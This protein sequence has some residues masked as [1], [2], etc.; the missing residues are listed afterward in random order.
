[1]FNDNKA[2]QVDL[3]KF[4][5][6]IRRY[7]HAGMSLPTSVERYQKNC[8]KESVKNIVAVILKDLKNGS[9][10]SAS[11]RKHTFFP[12]Y[13]IELVYIGES[14]GQLDKIFDEIVFFL[15][16]DIDITRELS[17]GLLPV[18]FFLVGAITA[19]CVA[20]F[21][22]IPKMGGIL[23]DLHADMPLLTKVVLKIG[24]T[25][26]DFW[27]LF[28]ILA[29]G[30]FFFYRY[31]KTAYPEMID[32]LKMKLPFYRTIYRNEMQYRFTKILSLCTVGNI[33]IVKSLQ[34]TALSIGNVPLK[35]ELMKAAKDC[36]MT[37]ANAADA[38]QKADVEH[39][40][41]SDIFIMLRAGE[42]S[43]NIYQIMMDEAEDYR[44]TL[45]SLSKNIGNKV[46]PSIIVPVMVGILFLMASVYAPIITMM[47]AGTTNAF[48]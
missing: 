8:E 26:Q 4:F 7:H 9:S 20:V 28:L 27:W 11:L 1:M 47:G 12:S 6:I 34:Y 18:K 14:S 44:K 32:R 24:T 31:A 45:L 37:G 16:Q 48:Q 43:G 29:V 21:V 42:I 23:D 5:R 41:E 15:E 17:T 3:C 30:T 40:L 33:P 39:L 25:L 19:F 46:G 38:I 36:E 22:V 35:N 2:T 10:F 13:I